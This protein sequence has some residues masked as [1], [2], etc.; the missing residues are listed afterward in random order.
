MGEAERRVVARCIEIIRET[1]D[2]FLSEQYAVGQPIA[3]FSERFACD[4]AAQAIENEFAM[5]TIEQC[6]LLG[7]P[8][9]AER[10]RDELAAHARDGGSDA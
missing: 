8:T 2:G 4:Q 5:G 7:K 10:Y 1:R 6:R 3:S 9:P